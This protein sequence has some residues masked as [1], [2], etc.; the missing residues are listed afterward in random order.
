MKKIINKNELEEQIL[1]AKKKINILGVIPFSLDWDKFKCS[2]FEQINRGDLKVEIFRESDWLINSYTIIAND[3][4]FSGESRS[5][6]YGDF[7]KQM[8][9]PL[10][11][12]RKYLVDRGCKNIEPERDVTEVGYKQCFALRTCY[13]P[14]S[15]PA[16]QIDEKYYITLGLTKFKNCD[17]FELVSEEHTWYPEL[18]KYFFGFFEY[19]NG[20]KKFS[21][22]ETKKGNRL[23][24]LQTY[25]FERKPVGVLPR[26]SFLGTKQLK[27]VVWGFVFTRDGKLLLHRRKENAK[28][29]RGMW[30]KSVG[31]HV[32]LGDVDTVKAFGREL[33]E[34]LYYVE[35]AEQGGHNQT[36]FIKVN[37]DKMIFLGE[38][39]PTRRFIAPFVDMNYNQNE[40]YSFS[41]TIINSL[42]CQP[43]GETIDASM[44]VDIYVCVA[45]RGFEYRLDHLMNSD[46]ALLETYE[47][48]DCYRDKTIKIFKSGKMMEELFEVTSDLRY[49]MN[50]SII[51]EL[52]RFSDYLKSQY[53]K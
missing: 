39:M 48:R 13:L 20:A 1:L 29:N 25:N 30:D 45:G 41:K 8:E 43:D 53:F 22:E 4:K 36:D 32:A 12:L 15:I 40:Y 42:R 38:W 6:E 49:V 14:I 23:E 7:K 37:E 47:L 19:E 17:K 51:D 34:E 24:V 11:N 52:A 26:D 5:Y 33:A 21:T 35:K 46:Y 50:S 9:G 16:I 3:K 2:W 31:G 28:D 18:Q 27:S 10:N 44:F